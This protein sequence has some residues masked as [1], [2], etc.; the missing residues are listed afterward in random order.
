VSCRFYARAAKIR[1]AYHEMA[2]D[3]QGYDIW[4]VPF[5]LCILNQLLL[6]LN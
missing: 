1:S 4:A 2:V 5:V 6:V 3:L